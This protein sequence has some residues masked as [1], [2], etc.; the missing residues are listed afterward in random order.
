V[1]QPSE[2]ILVP[3][4]CHDDSVAVCAR[5]AGTI[6]GV[7]SRP[8]LASGWGRAVR[9]GLVH[10]S[11]SLLAYSNSARANPEELVLVLLYAL[12][13]EG[14]VVKANRKI[15]ESALRRLGSLAYNL[16]C[17]ALFDLP[18][19]DI[20]GT[21]KVFPRA[22]GRLLELTSDDDLI[23]AEFA[24]ICRQEGYPVVEVPVISTR[25]HGGRSTTRLATAFRLY[26]GAYRMWAGRPK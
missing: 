18:T 10:A 14:V 7:L 20:N 12:A 22:F 16:E 9:H 6:P 8:L 15:R 25:R 2:L 23:D 21:P 1:P 26:W 3:N 17:R 19:W 24:V 4:G 5:L 11:G 13:Y